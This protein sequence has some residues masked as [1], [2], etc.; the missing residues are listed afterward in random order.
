MTNRDNPSKRDVILLRT[1]ALLQNIDR[2]A[3]EYE[4][5]KPPETLSWIQKKLEDNSYLLLVT[6]EA[7][8]GKSTFVNALI[9]R[10]ILPTDVDIA[11]CQ[12]FRV[13]NAPHEAFS[14]RFEDGSRQEIAVTDLPRYGSQGVVDAKGDLRL[15]QK[16]RWIEID[17]PAKFL[18]AG[19]SVL[20]TPGL[21]S[22]Y[23]AHAQITLRFIPL[24]DAV[25]F[26]LDS[27][28]PITAPE[29]QFLNTLLK[30]TTQIF[31]VQT[32]I[33]AYR[34]EDWR[35][36]QRR[37]EEILG[38]RF[39]DRLPEIQVWPVASADILRSVQTGDADYLLVSGQPELSDA[40]QEFLF[41][42]AG[43]GRAV[44]ALA[45]ADQYHSAS[46]SVLEV[47]L[48]SLKKEALQ[49]QEQLEQISKQRLA[50]FRTDW[51]EGGSKRHELLSQVENVALA[52]RETLQRGLHPGG[53]IESYQLRRI[54]AVRSKDDAEQI[55]T[56][57]AGEVVAAASELWRQM[58]E[59]T[60][61]SCAELLAPLEGAANSFNIL[62]SVGRV[63]VDEL[64]SSSAIQGSWWEKKKAV[65]MQK[66]IVSTITQI[67]AKIY[68]QTEP[69]LASGFLFDLLSWVVWDP[70]RQLKSQLEKVMGDVQ[71][72]FLKANPLTGQH[73]LVDR[74]YEALSEAMSH[75]VDVVASQKLQNESL[76]ID[77]LLQAAA[78]DD[79]KRENLH[80]IVRTQLEEWIMLGDVLAELVKEMHSMEDL[81]KPDRQTGAV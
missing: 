20:D 18:P 81:G 50:Q 46:R 48:A 63:G 36:V 64:S 49:K 21:G 25:I 52:G 28:R 34:E 39:N 75:R 22:L 24:A 10:E 79:Q 19:L 70:K 6:G 80:Q 35:A 74:Y 44:D 42:A 78:L 23:A 27:E 65:Q 12:A 58:T 59:Q 7:K 53:E 14:L 40:L 45:A 67:V 62:D 69:Y 55:G 9:G 2:K 29:I 1:I 26:V 68:P 56:A 5:P 41:R 31:F 16:I 4:L 15:D 66:G 77:R 60:T 11:T 33:D 61:H 47:R 30:A 72:Y 37:N 38:Q 8:R 3:E 54:E 71:S 43:W 17:L 51:E 73:S 13:S 57:L 32:K 76:E